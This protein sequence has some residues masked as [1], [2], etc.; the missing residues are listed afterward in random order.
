MPLERAIRA[1]VRPSDRNQG[2]SLEATSIDALHSTQQ[3]SDATNLDP[4]EGNAESDSL[5]DTPQVVPRRVRVSQLKKSRAEKSK[6]RRG[7]RNTL[8]SLTRHSIEQ[9]NDDL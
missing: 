4:R 1:V 6:K 3:P 5:S 8:D 7:H 2:K 9:G